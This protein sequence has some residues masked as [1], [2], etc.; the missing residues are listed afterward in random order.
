MC[1]TTQTDFNVANATTVLVQPR[2]YA[3]RLDAVFVR[4][5]VKIPVPVVDGKFGPCRNDVLGAPVYT[6]MV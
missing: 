5:V 6:K 2:N 4:F 1:D 3:V